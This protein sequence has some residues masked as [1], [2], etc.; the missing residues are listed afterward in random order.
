MNNTR[1]RRG[2]EAE[3]E[4]VRKLW[5]RGFAVIRAPASGARA[6]L[7]AYP[8]IVAIFKGRIYAIEVKYRRDNAPI[9]IDRTQLEKLIEFSRRAGAT[10]LIAV[11]R[12]HKGWKLISIDQVKGTN[13]GR[14]KI[15]DEVLNNGVS[16]DEFITI[17][18]NT[19]LRKFMKRVDE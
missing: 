1:R 5:S 14:I 4:L 3:R 8:D 13:T 15:D 10:P 2:F 7:A 17:A 19:G 12:A 18:T 11:K 6:R 9:Y 16:L